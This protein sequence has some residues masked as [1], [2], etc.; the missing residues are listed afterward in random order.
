MK[1]SFNLFDEQNND[2]LFAPFDIDLPEDYELADLM[3]DD[4][5]DSLSP[6]M[7]EASTNKAEE[8]VSIAQTNLEDG[9]TATVAGCVNVI[10]GKFFD[11]ATDLVIP[12]A[13]PLTLRRSY[14]SEE[15]KWRF[16]HIPIL[17]IKKSGHHVYG[18]YLDESGGAAYSIYTHSFKKVSRIPLSEKMI[19][20]GLS[21]WN[22]GFISGQTNWKNATLTY[23][24]RKND[25]NDKQY[26]LRQGNHTDRYFLRYKRYGK[27]HQSG[28][29]DG[30]FQLVKEINPNGNQ[31]TYLYNKDDKLT[32]V[33]ALN[34]KGKLLSV[35][36]HR[37][38]EHNSIWS[39]HG[40]N[41][42]YLMSDNKHLFCVHPSHGVHNHYEYDEHDRVIRKNFPKNRFIELDYV[43]INNGG[44]RVCWLKGPLGTDAT[45]VKTH[46][47]SYTCHKNHGTTTVFD[48]FNNKTVYQH[49]NQRL[50]KVAHYDRDKLYSCDLF[51]WGEFG[52]GINVGN[53]LSRV[54][55]DSKTTYFCRQLKYDNFG[56]VTKNQLWGN[57]YGN[58]YTTP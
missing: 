23:L 21:N 16:Q 17:K 1:Q 36:S 54:F 5:D 10:S 19:K 27:R 20:K 15:K 2:S 30:K 33:K 18:S 26:L 9:P 44:S 46:R 53:L 42:N 55:K 37:K 52:K 3:E 43:H 4:E 8:E 14:N 45:P 28:A 47:F 25:W 24:K 31:F 57:L 34:R 48:A 38:K 32:Q 29:H 12:G 51:Y 56:N 13:H 40:Q 39:S 22:S 58:E 11:F 50:T 35:L 7:K 41:V 49:K 6:L